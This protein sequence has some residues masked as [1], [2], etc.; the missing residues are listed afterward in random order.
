MRAQRKHQ[1]G[2]LIPVMVAA[3]VAVVGQVVILCNDFGPENDLH[4]NE[5]TRMITAAVLSRAGAVEI[6]SEPLAGRP[7]A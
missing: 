4:A 6:P 1:R 2:D 7:T 5:S 3:C